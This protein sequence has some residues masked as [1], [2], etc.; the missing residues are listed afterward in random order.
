MQICNIKVS[1]EFGSTPKKNWPCLVKW[2][3]TPSHRQ[4]TSQ[5]IAQGI[6]L[7]ISPECQFIC[8]FALSE[9]LNTDFYMMTMALGYYIA[10]VNKALLSATHP[11]PMSDQ[12]RISL[13][14]VNTA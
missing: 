9:Q 14:S 2:W 6:L 8:W 1:M 4:I 11:T 10:S 5:R 13:Y 12:D 7:K 3:I